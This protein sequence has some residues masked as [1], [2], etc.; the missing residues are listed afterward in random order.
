MKTC[1]RGHIFTGRRCLECKKQRLNQWRKDNPGY[2]KSYH[3]QKNFGIT[4]EQFNE[5]F[6]SQ[7][8]KCRICNK[9][10][11][12]LRITLA[13]DHNHQTGKIRGLLC[14]GCNRGIGFLKESKE[15]LE[16]AIKYLGET[17]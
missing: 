10:Q 6:N 9:H 16:N 7:E 13:V 2:V 1:K 17:N 11:S 4:L 15:I 8:G 12:E 3:L 5:M 14:D